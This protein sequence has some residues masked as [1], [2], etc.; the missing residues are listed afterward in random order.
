MGSVGIWRCRVKEKESES[1]VCA[2]KDV[3]KE[4]SKANK[5]SFNDGGGWKVCREFVEWN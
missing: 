4:V 3:G 1:G 5:K 2:C